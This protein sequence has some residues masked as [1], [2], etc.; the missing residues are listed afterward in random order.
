MS[1]KRVNR[2]F[3]AAGRARLQELGAQ[4]IDRWVAEGLRPRRVAASFWRAAIRQSGGFGA[5]GELTAEHTCIKI[6]RL[7]MF[8]MH[9]PTIGIVSMQTLG[10]AQR[11][12]V[13]LGVDP[14]R[15]R[16]LIRDRS[17]QCHDRQR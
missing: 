15:V 11:L 5:T 1:A 10:K 6:K 7:V 16:A 17:A 4:D 8:T 12:G 3:C 9:Y 13:E 2:T 14:E